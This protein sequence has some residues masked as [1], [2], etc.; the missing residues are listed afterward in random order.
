[1]SFWL[2]EIS[3]VSILF[4]SELTAKLGFKPSVKQIDTIE[5]LANSHL[6]LVML[7][8]IRGHNI[9]HIKKVWLFHKIYNKAKDYKTILS[10]YWKILDGKWIKGVSNGK[11]AIFLFEVTIKAIISIYRSFF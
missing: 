1:M 3:L 7:D 10:E 2:I 9:I 5:E 11:Y 4:S 8:G 6:K